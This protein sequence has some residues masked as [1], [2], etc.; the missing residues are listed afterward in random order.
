MMENKLSPA[1]WTHQTPPIR[2]DLWV[3]PFIPL[4]H[5]TLRRQH[6]DARTDVIKWLFILLDQVDSPDQGT[7]GGWDKTVLASEITNAHHRKIQIRDLLTSNVTA[8]SLVWASTRASRKMLR[9]QKPPQRDR[10]WN[11]GEL[12]VREDPAWR[13]G[14]SGPP[15]QQAGEH[16]EH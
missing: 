6:T 13:T 14:I 1:S 2:T 7:G 15:Q 12:P 3:K 11:L 8:A 4:Q 9:D 10:G 5:S 16:L